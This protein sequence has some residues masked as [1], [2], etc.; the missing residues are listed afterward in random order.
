MRISDW[1]SDVCSSD[2]ILPKQ[3]SI[4]FYASG[5]Q[6]LG[7]HVSLFARG[8]YAKRDFEARRRVIGV[9][10]QFVT[11]DNPYYVDPIGTGEEIMRS[12]EH[13]SELQSLMRI[14]YA[15][16]C[17]KKKKTHQTTCMK[18]NHEGATTQY[19]TAITRHRAYTR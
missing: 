18:S 11:P 17:L 2:L 7:D 13:T 4:S 5:E 15:V 8:L 16:F 3:E 6:Q 19:I 14:S 12:E 1:S 10:Q 9:S